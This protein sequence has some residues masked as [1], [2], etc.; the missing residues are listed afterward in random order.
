MPHNHTISTARAVRVSGTQSLGAVNSFSNFA[1][2]S[3]WKS[4]NNFVI[5]ILVRHL[6]RS[7]YRGHQWNPAAQQ[8][9]SAL[10]LKSH[11]QNRLFDESCS[12]LWSCSIRLQAVSCSCSLRD[13][14]AHQLP[15][16]PFLL[17]QNDQ[18]SAMPTS[19]KAVFR[20][21]RGLFVLIWKRQNAPLLRTL[22]WIAKC[23]CYFHSKWT[24]HNSLV[25]CSPVGG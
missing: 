5:L 12:Q 1:G 4:A 23:C 20:A 19:L 15:L 17:F 22:D 10:S 16:N 14:I 7:A 21:K 24:R 13:H 3:K 18:L 9:V 8:R 11:Q 2:C 6:S 25:S